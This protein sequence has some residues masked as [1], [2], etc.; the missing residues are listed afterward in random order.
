MVLG[1]EQFRDLGVL[2]PAADVIPGVL[3]DARVRL[4]TGEEVDVRILGVEAA[5]GPGA[6]EL[7]FQRPVVEVHDCDVGL[8][9]HVAG[10]GVTRPL[11]HLR[12]AGLVGRLGIGIHRSVLRR[13]AVVGRALE[14]DELIG[15]PGDLRDR[16]DAGRAGADDGDPLAGE[17]D[18]LVRPLTGV[19]APP[20]NRSMPSI[21][22]QLGIERQPV[23]MIRKRAATRSPFSAPTVHRLLKASKCALVIRAPKWKCRR[24]SSVVATRSM[25]FR[26]SGCSE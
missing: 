3:G 16:L 2:Y 22:G 11:A 10:D 20:R 8:G 24:R 7:A 13:N 5:L 19:E 17:V 25:Y 9:H 23:A 26:I 6:I 14:D 21:A 1:A 4:V 15:L 18:A 12:V